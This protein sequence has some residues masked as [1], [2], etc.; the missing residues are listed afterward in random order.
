MKAID[1]IFYKF[2][3]VINQHRMLG[4]H[5]KKLFESLASEAFSRVFITFCVGLLWQEAQRKCA[6]RGHNLSVPADKL[7]Y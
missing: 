5:E 4:E 6:L 3:T 2:S 7:D 1:C